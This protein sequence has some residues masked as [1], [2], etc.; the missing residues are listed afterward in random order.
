MFID[1]FQQIEEAITI[2][3]IE[4]IKQKIAKDKSIGLYVYNALLEA[5][6]NRLLVM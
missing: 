5:I 1:Y 4:Q 3:E 2:D 6:N